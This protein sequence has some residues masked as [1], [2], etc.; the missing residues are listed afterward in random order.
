MK[1]LVIAEKPSVARDIANAL[2]RIKKAGD[3]FENETYVVSSAVGHL[4]EL[5]MPEDMD[6]KL[7]FWKLEVLPILPKK[8]DLKPIEKTKAKFQELKKLMAREDVGTIVNACDAGREGELIFTYIYELAKCKKPVQRLWMQ[9]MTPQGIR[10]AFAH[11]R[12]G[13]EL[14]PLREAA[15]SRSEADWLIGINGTRAVTTRMYG[16]RRGMVATVGRVQTPTLALVVERERQIRQFVPR[17]YWRISGRFGITE[18]EYEGLYQ[19]PDFKKGADDEDKA[20]RLW[21]EV[22]ANRILQ[23]AQRFPKA[24][25]TEEKKR[26]QQIAPRLY[27][28][29]TLQREANNRFGLPAEATLRI[30]QALYEKH[31]AITY[32]RTDARALPEDYQHTVKQTLAAIENNYP[33]ARKVLEQNWVRPNKRIF[34]NKEVSDHFAIIPTG[35]TESKFTPDEEKIFDMIARRF[36]AA[37]FPPAEYDETTRLSQL[38]PHTFK[39]TGKV[40]V[41]PGWLE[42]YG[43]TEKNDTL[44]AL[45]PPDGQPPQARMLALDLL[46]ETTKPPAHYTEAT[47]LSAMEGAG[48]LLEDEEL[49][50]AMKE[51]GLGTPATRAQ[52]IEHLIHETYLERHGRDLLCTAKAEGLIDF[53][54]AIKAE[55]LTSPVMTGEWEYKLRQI[56]EKKLSR[57]EFM[58]GIT[59]VT[60]RLVSKV[61]AFQEKAEDH[62]LTDII[63]PTDLRPML[64]TLRAYKSQD[65]LVTIYKSVGNRLMTT[66]E[67]RTLVTE[68]RLGPLD[69]FRSKAGKPFSAILTLDEAWKVKF[70]FNN[71]RPD[72]AGEGEATADNTGSS[73]EPSQPL[74]LSS[75]RVVGPSPIDGQPV[76]ETPNAYACAKTLRGEK[77]GFRLSRNMLG[78]VLPREQVEKLLQHGETDLLEKF[79]SKR[80]GRF[81]SAHLTW[82]NKAKGE[83]GFKF[84]ERTPKPAS[85]GKTAKKAPAAT[86]DAA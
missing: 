48:K 43:R 46:A 86:D 2:G 54:A 24:D 15:R 27:D 42:V 72:S 50:A 77:G 59:E 31:K 17:P 18:G 51:K 32:P 28:L 29:T 23:E 5:F 37:F 64:E 74:D 19:R 85:Q 45:S 8:F 6:E 1:T 61:K 78:R 58:Q 39:T 81:F 9:S 33:S 12:P 79:K 20:D 41:L 80:N 65:G 83:I 55:D 76:Y 11:L 71:S 38:G 47:L 7:R 26:T 4:V 10:D 57:S 35:Q 84:A 69:G 16:S 22:E 70:V 68:K 30:A 49:A 66:E 52:I 67:I 36:I 34:N 56:E 14:Q 44:P 21:S 25:V 63:S 73:G 3:W 62:Q 40:L 75:L 82:K 13:A 53:L 60:T